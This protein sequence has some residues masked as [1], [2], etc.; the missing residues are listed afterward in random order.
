ME[1]GGLRGESIVALGEV[2]DEMNVDLHM[3]P[4]I[5]T[6]RNCEEYKVTVSPRD[7]KLTAVGGCWI[8]FNRL[9]PKI[10]ILYN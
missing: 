3:V 1:G 6:L 7:K 9:N 2:G 10:F 8:H 4:G 5:L